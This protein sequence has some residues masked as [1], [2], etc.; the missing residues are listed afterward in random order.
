MMEWD[1]HFIDYVNLIDSLNFFN[2]SLIDLILNVEILV[3]KGSAL[4]NLGYFSEAIV[5]L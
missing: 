5:T 3:N 2:Q 4:E 1:L